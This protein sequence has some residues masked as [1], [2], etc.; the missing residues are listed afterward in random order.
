MTIIYILGQDS[1]GQ[2][3]FFTP[4][5]SSLDAQL[6]CNTS[7][8]GIDF[9]GS[10]KDPFHVTSFITDITMLCPNLTGHIY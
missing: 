2:S 5:S 1:K 8:K 4:F 10:G 6:H 9:S 7:H 3:G